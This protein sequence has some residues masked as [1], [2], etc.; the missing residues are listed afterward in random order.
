MTTPERIN[1]QV[2]EGEFLF[3]GRRVR[4]READVLYA[5][6]SKK[7]LTR[8]GTISRRPAAGGGAGPQPPR[9]GVSALFGFPALNAG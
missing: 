2:K 8:G 1:L 3:D 6:C 5:C 7:K 4:L 9:R